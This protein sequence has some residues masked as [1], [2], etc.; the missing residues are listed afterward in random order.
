MPVPM[1]RNTAEV[2]DPYVPG[3]FDWHVTESTR[4][5]V[6]IDPVG[7]YIGVHVQPGTIEAPGTGP[8]WQ[9]DG[10][11][12]KPTLTPSVLNLAPG[13]WHGWVRGGE[14]VDA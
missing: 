7:H 2:W 10:N 11:E 5:L 14:L 1:R 9:W 8:L 4:M 3:D 6:F 13:G 12:D